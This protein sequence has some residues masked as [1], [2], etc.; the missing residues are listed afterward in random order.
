M[1]S[2]N[3]TNTLPSWLDSETRD[4][5]KDVIGVLSERHPDLI[6]VILY[7]SVARHEERSLE[8]PNPS[9]VDLLAVLDSDDPHVALHQGDA[10]FH[11]LGLAYNRHLDAPREV[12]VMFT[13]RTLQEWDPTF[14]ANVMRDGIVLYT[15]GSLPAPFAA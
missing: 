6:A 7:G 5:I 10:L 1:P 9:D 8:A 13:S 2:V 15:R 14:I 3:R 4:L 11:T 12:K